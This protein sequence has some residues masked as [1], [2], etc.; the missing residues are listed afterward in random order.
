[1]PALDPVFADYSCSK[2]FAFIRVANILRVSPTRIRAASLIIDIPAQ[3]RGTLPSAAVSDSHV[4]RR[5]KQPTDPHSGPIGAACFR[6]SG[7][8]MLSSK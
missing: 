5:L 3:L 2:Y 6:R 1:L 4:R 8:C 7:I